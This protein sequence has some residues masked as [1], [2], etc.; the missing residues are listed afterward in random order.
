MRHTPQTLRKAC[1]WTDYRSHLNSNTTTG[2]L[3]PEWHSE[4]PSGISVYTSSGYNS[5]VITAND[6]TQPEYRPKNISLPAQPDDPVEL[7]ATVAQH[8]LGVGGT[9]EIINATDSRNG[10][11]DGPAGTVR[12]T[13]TT[14]TLPAWVGFVLDN[15]FEFVD[16]CDKHVLRAR[17]SADTLQTVWF[18]RLAD[19]AGA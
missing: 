12:G 2:E 4:Y 3:I 8:S 10:T 18:Y 19:A 13:F 14:A 17:F 7:W 15:E 5:F 11:A 16:G 9:F 1:T 6:T